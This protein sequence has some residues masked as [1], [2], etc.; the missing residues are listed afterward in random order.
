[1]IDPLVLIRFVMNKAAQLI[2]RVIYEGKVASYAKKAKKAGA[3]TTKSGSDVIATFK[4]SSAARDFIDDH[5]DRLPY[6]VELNA[7]GKKVVI[8]K[9]DD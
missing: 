2:E 5:E 8:Q 6:G 1:M 4:S 7:R 9:M 3:T